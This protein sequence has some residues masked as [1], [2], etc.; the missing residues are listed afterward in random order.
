MIVLVRDHFEQNLL[1]SLIREIQRLFA[2]TLNLASF[3]DSELTEFG[4]D[5]S[6]TLGRAIGTSVCIAAIDQRRSVYSTDLISP[7]VG[8]MSLSC[9]EPSHDIALAGVRFSRS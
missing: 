4:V 8:V 9:G 3:V 5:S 7:K 6:N 1:T 2:V